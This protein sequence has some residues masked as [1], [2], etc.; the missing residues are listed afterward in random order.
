MW[1]ICTKHL[2]NKNASS[3]RRTTRLLTVSCS[4]RV[5]GMQ[6]PLWMQNHPGHVTCDACWEV[7]P[8]PGQNDRRLWKYYLEPNFVCGVVIRHDKMTERT[9]QQSFQ[10][11]FHVTSSGFP[12]FPDWQN[13]LT[14]PVFFSNF[15]FFLMFC[16]VFFTENL[17]HFSK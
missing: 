2:V 8:P 10:V 5:G 16:F 13:S 12:L 3:R 14:F 1:L 7:N 11:R 15:P 17:I 4:A 6:T 9:N